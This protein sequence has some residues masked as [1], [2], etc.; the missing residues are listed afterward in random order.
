M[1]TFVFFIG[2]TGARVLRSLTMLMAS[3]VSLKDGDSIVPIMVDYDATN[4]DL[5]RTHELLGAY[6]EF[7]KI[8]DYDNDKFEGGF[9]RTPMGLK[10][11]GQHKQIKSLEAM[12][13][14][15][16]KSTFGG[17]IGYDSL[18]SQNLK[19]EVTK[20]LLDSLYDKSSSD[21]RDRELELELCYGFKGNPNI[22][23]VVFNEY[24][25]TEQYQAFKDNFSPGDRIFIVASIFGGTGSSGLPQLV[26]KVR[27]TAMEQAQNSG[28]TVTAINQAMLG[29][30]VVLPYFNVKEREDSAINSRT[31]NSKAKA[32]L[33]YYHEEINDKISEI[34]YIGCKET[35]GNYENNEGGEKQENKAHIVELLS[36]M[37]IVEFANHEEIKVVPGN[38]PETKYYEYT[39]TSTTDKLPEKLFL[40][41]L[42]RPNGEHIYQDYVKKLNA[43]ALLARFFRE[44][45]RNEENKGFLKPK[46]S[47]YRN[48]E[49]FL[50]SGKHFSD[51]FYEFTNYFI[52]W[53]NELS[54]NDILPFFPYNFNAKRIHELIQM[55]NS[56]NFKKYDFE[57][58]ITRIL[59]E[60]SAQENDRSSKGDKVYLRHAYR[61]CIE[62]ISRVN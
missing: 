23:S 36:A 62:A 32:A 13:F 49:D 5:K 1:K 39:T 8:C 35:S 27:E 55:D 42:S 17:Y 51:K 38:K 43:F 31:F 12:T 29:A 7:H 24:F 18:S 34:F 48:L 58:I 4:A 11:G 59:N 60:G 14:E 10:D 19:C 20:M 33:N 25:R 28:S 37:S 50:H 30:C 57:D 16:N 44:F 2:G 61:A 56:G 45:T 9:F 26:K 21:S 41:M 3:G 46:N 53:A 52:N 40:N 54:E 22:G 15:G 6:N 47:Y